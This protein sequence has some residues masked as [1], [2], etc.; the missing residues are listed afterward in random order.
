MQ[1]SS[2]L[3]GFAYM[4][5]YYPGDYAA[6]NWLNSHVQGNP[7][8]VEAYGPSGGDYTSYARISSFTGLPTL[9]G[10]LG[11]EYQ[12]RVNWLN[13][14]SN[15]TDFYRRGTDINTIYTS[16]DSHVVL[17]LL[18]Y[19]HV[20]YLYVGSLEISTYL[21]SNLDRFRQF[22]PIVYS[23]QGVTIYEVPGSA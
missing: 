19:Y 13:N 18:T 14:S 22:L 7:V 9:M 5:Q 2:S 16:T 6:I 3:D 4:Q 10:W 17:G 12:W 20:K 23:A 11:H 15:M 8:I 21:G 1:R